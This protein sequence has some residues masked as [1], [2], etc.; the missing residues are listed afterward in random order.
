VNPS[1]VVGFLGAAGILA[2]AITD[3]KGASDILLDP[4]AVTLVVGGT[5]AAGVISFPVGRIFRMGL[6]GLKRLLGFSGTDYG[7]VIREV[8]T[9]AEG[10]NRDPNF[11]KGAVAG[12]KDPFLKDGVQLLVNG[13]TE[14]QLQDIL[15]T[16]IETFKRR[17]AEEVNMF[18]VLGKFPPAFGLL[19]TT[20]GMISLL[21]QLGAADAIKKVGPAMAVGLVA[22][23]YGIAL[24]NFL[25]IPIAENL[26]ASNAESIAARKMILDGL[27]LIKRR[28]HP[29]LVEEKMLSYLLPSERAQVA[30]KGKGAS[31]GGAK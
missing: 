2:F 10:S 6:L 21:S 17:Q 27:I 1:S 3:A 5:T 31:K 14:E 29:I 11:L 7:K 9:V 26:K 25:F 23:L 20:F 15:Q 16:R 19:G 28:T 18:T 12:L 24:T 30:S 8:I 22:T 4:H 13:A